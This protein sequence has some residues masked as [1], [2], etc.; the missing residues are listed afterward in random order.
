M[1]YALT[2]LLLFQL[3]G[4]AVVQFFAL[5]IPGPV[6]GMALLFA[7]MGLR[8]AIADRLRRPSGDLLQHLSLLFVP[9]GVG[10]MLHA[11]RVADEWAAIVTAVVLSTAITIAV[12]ALTIRACIYWQQRRIGARK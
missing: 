6:I 5:P 3:A 11:R 2:A 10:V 9:A 4:E 12:T 1:L 7:A 8:P